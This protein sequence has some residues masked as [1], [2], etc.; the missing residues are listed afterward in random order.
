MKV[1]NSFFKSSIIYVLG[2]FFTAGLAF[3]TTPIFTRI[4]SLEEYGLVAIFT[5][6]VNIIMIIVGLQT[7]GTISIANIKFKHDELNS[8]LSSVLFLSTLSFF[9]IS[10]VLLIFGKWITDLMD[11]TLFLLFV[12]LLQSFFAYV[13]QFYNTY[14]I[15]TKKPWKS[16]LLS[17]SFSVLATI[18]SVI[19][20]FTFQDN[21]HLGPILGKAIVV[22]IYGV[23][24]YF[25]VIKK[26]KITINKSYWKFCLP[27]SI[28]LIFHLLA[29]IIL[30]Q[31]D[32]IIL[33][34]YVGNAEVGIYTFSYTLA[35]I[36]AILWQALNKAWVP[37][38]FEN[39]KSNNYKVINNYAKVYLNIFLIV[40]IIIM[41]LVPEIMY[42]LGPPEYRVG[43]RVTLVV[44]LGI[45]FNFLYSFLSNYEFYTE[46]TKWI[47]V[48][49]IAAALINI[50]L[51]IL[52]IP[53]MHAMGAAI[54]TLISY[55][56]LF[57]FHSII[58]TNIKGY[59]IQ[60]KMII[61]NIVLMVLIFLFV[62]IIFENI[63]IRMLLILTLI[64][65]LIFMLVRDKKIFRSKKK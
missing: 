17:V 60:Y 50:I 55:I 19:L 14:L 34:K 33:Q 44:M 15:Q 27:L 12:I 22:V 20:V 52:L 9:A 13:Q 4:L 39:T 35:S 64:I 47:A 23:I 38:Y 10:S 25:I 63:V 45:Y 3:L 24:C 11:I 40:T 65:T 29:A 6:W 31:S 49:T 58:A 43:D 30:S 59:N 46:N 41:L 48:G 26:S 51:N 32:K 18:L 61:K 62:N 8:Y 57:I 37:W 21:K 28:P 53:S 1:K 5:T 56:M 54:A 2:S 7:S 16:L 36:L 42:I